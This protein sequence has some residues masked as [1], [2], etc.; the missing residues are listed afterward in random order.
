MSAAGPVEFTLPSS[1]LMVKLCFG[2]DIVF[3]EP[4]VDQ[5]GGEVDRRRAFI[6]YRYPFRYVLVPLVKRSCELFSEG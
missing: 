2:E 3:R 1:G 6:T 5:I 4:A